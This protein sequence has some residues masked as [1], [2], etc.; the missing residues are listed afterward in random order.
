MKVK[1]RLYLFGVLLL[2]RTTR[3]EPLGP[4]YQGV[5]AAGTNSQSFETLLVK[6]LPFPRL[7][8]TSRNDLDRTNH[9]LCL[10]Y[11]LRIAQAETNGLL[12]KL[13]RERKSLPPIK[14]GA[15]GVLG[16]HTSGPVLANPRLNIRAKFP[17]PEERQWGFKFEPRDGGKIDGIYHIPGPE[18]RGWI[19]R[20]NQSLLAVFDA[21]KADIEARVNNSKA[22]NKAAEASWRQHS[23]MTKDGDEFARSTLLREDAGKKLMF[24]RAVVIQQQDED[25]KIAAAQRELEKINKKLERVIA[26]MNE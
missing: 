16:Q 14:P 18:V 5:N 4:K 1:A 26:A 15:G 9:K 10:L 13:I 20:T 2:L 22:Q 6:G 11:D 21:R 23:L 3:G 7:T 25:Y 12:A 24:A 19:Q 8:Q 17:L